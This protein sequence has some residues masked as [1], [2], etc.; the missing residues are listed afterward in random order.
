MIHRAKGD[1]DTMRLFGFSPTRT[2]RATWTLRELDI[3]YEPITENVSQHPEL[4][5]F[6]PLR[7]VPA[8]DV[9][10]KGLFE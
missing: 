10:G 8:L 6:H 9:D 7:R 2:D 1:Y 5:R 3:D 4:E